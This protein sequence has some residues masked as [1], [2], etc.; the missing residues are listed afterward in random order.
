VL[1]DQI[2]SQSRG[3]ATT[4]IKDDYVESLM[5][6]LEA[7]DRGKPT[8]IRQLPRDLKLPGCL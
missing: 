4:W 8:R 1:Y 7:A 6:A 3:K 2:T 5:W